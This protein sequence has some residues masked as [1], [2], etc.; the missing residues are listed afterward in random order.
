MELLGKLGFI[1][2]EEYTGGCVE[3][4]DGTE[5]VCKTAANSCM[6]LMVKSSAFSKGSDSASNSEKLMLTTGFGAPE[7]IGGGSDIEAVEAS[8]SVSGEEAAADSFS[9]PFSTLAFSTYKTGKN[10][11]TKFKPKIAN[12]FSKYNQKVKMI[13]F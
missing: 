3:N 1:T 10:G 11:L 6:S 2:D 12:I 5:V 13:K 8:V 7:W 4:D 9:A